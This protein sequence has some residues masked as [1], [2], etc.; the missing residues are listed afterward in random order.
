MKIKQTYWSKA[1]LVH[2]IRVGRKNGE[3]NGFKNIREAVERM[4][5]EVEEIKVTK[6]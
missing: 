4:G 3:N 6:A 5:A 1:G 2:L